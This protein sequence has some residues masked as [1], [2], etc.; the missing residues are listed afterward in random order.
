MK[1]KLKATLGISVIFLFAGVASLLVF[2]TVLLAEYQKFEDIQNAKDSARVTEALEQ[3]IGSLKVR[4]N[5]WGVWDE[6]YRFVMEQSPEFITSNLAYDA[7][8]ANKL[9][10]IIYI[11]SNLQIVHGVRLDI[12]GK[13]VDQLEEHQSPDIDDIVR[14]AFVRTALESSKAKGGVL[15]LHGKMFMIA[16]SPIKDS[17]G[18]KQSN[19]V[20]LFSR[21]VTQEL[22]QR[23]SSQTQ[24]KVRIAANNREQ[25][26]SDKSK[27]TAWGDSKFAPPNFHTTSEEIL[28][29][30]TCFDIYGAPIYNLLLELPRD[31]FLR[32]LATRKFFAAMFGGIGIVCAGLVFLLLNRLLLRRLA[33]LSSE[34]NSITEG[35]TFGARVLVS[36]NDELSSL[37]S[38]MNET[39]AAL[40]K[41]LETAKAS[42]KD[43]EQANDA[44]TGF[45][46]KVSH[47][48]RTPIHS[49]TG[50]LRILLREERTNSRRNYIMMARNAALGLLETINEILDFSKAEAGRLRIERIEF[51]LHNVIREA[52]QAIG[53]VADEKGALE[54]VVEVEPGLPS[55]LYGDPHRLQQ[56]LV[57][58]MGNSVKFT[59]EGVVG[60][61]VQRAVSFADHATVMFSVFDTGVGIPQEKLSSVFEPFTQADDSVTRMYTGTGLGL[62]IVKQLVEDMGGSISVCSQLGKG[63]E[64][65]LNI[66]FDLASGC[67]S[68][69]W[70]PKLSSQRVALIGA[71]SVVVKGYS[72]ELKALD[73]VPSMVNSFDNTVLSQLSLEAP[74][75]GLFIVTS[76]ALKRSRVFD[77]VIELSDRQIVPVVAILSPSEISIRERLIALRVP[78][79]VSRPISLQD[80]LALLEGRIK[81]GE[82][83]W[84]DGED[85]SLAIG[86]PLNVLVAD[87]APTNRLI[88]TELLKEAGH[89]VVCVEN[90][91]EM[92]NVIRESIHCLPGAQQFDI[93]LT[94]VQMPLLDGLNATRK[95]RELEE[96]IYG[97]VRIPIVAV[98]AHAMTEETSRMAEF[99]V[100]DVVTK[101]LDPTRLGD[102]IQRLT[103][104]QSGEERSRGVNPTVVTN[105]LDVTT[106]V[107]KI[108]RQLSSCSEDIRNIFSI[109]NHPF[110]VE[111]LSAVLDV[112]DVYQRSGNSLRRTLLIFNSFLD[113]YRDQIVR[114]SDARQSSDAA[115]LN[116]AAHAIRGILLDI[117]SRLPASLA[118]KIETLSKEGSLE[119]AR[120]LS[121]QL[122]KQVLSVARLLEQ[123]VSAVVFKEALP[124]PVVEQGMVRV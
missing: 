21:E 119:E 15:R 37:A 115:K 109:P 99:G 98:T 93:I 49:I 56:I 102:V 45:I 79:V 87:D 50:M 89:S 8:K 3:E 86:R 38:R 95:I 116:S 71:E 54:V 13:K 52:L 85:A 74:R 112:G 100:D 91:L 81:F 4:V 12:S 73:Y 31:I 53:P 83:R 28:G 104:A 90:G 62:T 6:S 69:T 33:C 36:G 42:Q 58:L 55:I 120:G 27:V 57:N 10:H 65:T 34:L 68:E 66:P 60:L 47:E 117:G 30:I 107:W 22:I 19:G 76:E 64:F 96:T 39:L 111:D 46:A 122:A 16:V 18:E 43:A 103:G 106:V 14:S 26:F 17:A 1:L 78:F 80:I 9:D 32:G 88:L 110:D 7:L 94:D 59:K 77:L 108:W 101:P 63:S 23:V 51:R 11:N 67:T 48:L 114:L 113:C 121:T 44:K 105:E 124:M 82:E 118:G 97:R 70:N 61:K 40:S 5:D 29:T 24:I 35:A 2:N 72:N 41:A 123:L 25:R 84:N 20:L 75:F 92:V